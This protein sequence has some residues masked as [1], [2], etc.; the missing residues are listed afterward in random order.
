MSTLTTIAGLALDG[1]R[2]RERIG[3]LTRQV[4]TGQKGTLHGDLG[5]EARRAV[6]LRGE[7][8]RREAAAAAADRA[9]ARTGTAGRVLDRLHGLASE[10]AAE[11][12]RTLGA[13]AAAPL[14]ETA[15][16]A[17]A[18]AV[19]LLNT[20]HAEEHLFSGSDVGGR[21]LP[22]DGAAMRTAVAAEVGTLA[23]GNAAAVLAAT[24]AAASAPATTPFSAF[25]EGPA[26]A[27][28]LR[29]VAVAE[30]ERV[31]VGVLAN[32][33]GSAGPGASWG[34]ELLRGLAAL[35]AVTPAQAALGTDYDALLEG[36]RSAISGAADGIAADQ[37]ALGSAERRIEA[38]R[39][40]HADTLV[41]LRA[42][43]GQVEEVDPAAVMAELR[44]LQTRLEAS[45]QAT[46]MVANLSLAALLR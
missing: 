45:Y 41:M 46:S 13:S 27:E 40:R 28:P 20:A 37:G 5:P 11:A 12:A 18:E 34:R 23:P 6:D 9:L 19:A 16:A 35:S 22:D 1:A 36:L 4:S 26:L 14:A 30:G 8:A 17:F 7:I 44:A 33:P 31:A 24:E 32:R 43:L 10:V 21:P 25:V 42:S 2:M 3:T 38:A 29:A 39:E 15:R